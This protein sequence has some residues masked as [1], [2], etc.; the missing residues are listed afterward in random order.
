M[1]L[2]INFLCL[3]CSGINVWPSCCFSFRLITYFPTKYLIY[4]KS[5]ISQSTRFWKH[6]RPVFVFSFHSVFRWPLL[7]LRKRRCWE[8]NTRNIACKAQTPPLSYIPSDIVIGEV[9]LCCVVSFRAL[10]FSRSV[11]LCCRT[12]RPGK[13][14]LFGLLT[15][16]ITWPSRSLW[17]QRC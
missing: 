14:E 11:G 6:P 5:S 13:A 7:F 12:E 16:P 4:I 10:S 1:F 17:N 9:L 8:V 2:L 15:E 3:L